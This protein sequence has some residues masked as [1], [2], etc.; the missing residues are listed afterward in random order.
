MSKENHS[1]QKD[2]QAQKQ[3]NMEE[4]EA[5][6][7]NQIFSMLDQVLAEMEEETSLEESFQKYH[8][9]MDLLKL[10]NDKIDRIE[11][12]I[13]VLDEEGETHEF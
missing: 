3:E 5:L 11:K 1:N 12:Q 10:C 2:V 6:T 9:G 8:T 7:L 13:L 4:A